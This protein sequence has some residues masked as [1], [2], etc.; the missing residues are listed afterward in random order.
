MRLYPSSEVIAVIKWVSPI[1]ESVV[2]KQIDS[3][4]DNVTERRALS[5]SIFDIDLVYSNSNSYNL[6]LL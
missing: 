2:I 5:V 4:T 1:L 6:Y 3:V